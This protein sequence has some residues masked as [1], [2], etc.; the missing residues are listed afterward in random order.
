MTIAALS[1]G[2]EAPRKTTENTVKHRDGGVGSVVTNH[3]GDGK[4]SVVVTTVPTCEL[5]DLSITAFV[6]VAATAR[7]PAHYRLFFILA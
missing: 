3:R 6:G 4:S 5:V 2:S 1:S 7:N